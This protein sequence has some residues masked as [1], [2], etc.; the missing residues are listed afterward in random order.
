MTSRSAFS[1]FS[2][3]LAV[4]A[5]MS[6]MTGCMVDD[7]GHAY[8]DRLGNAET[9]SSWAER[10]NRT[11]EDLRAAI[12]VLGKR[13]R[14]STGD[15]GEQAPNGIVRI[16]ESLRGR[17]YGRVGAAQ[18]RDIITAAIVELRSMGADRKTESVP[19][20]LDRVAALCDADDVADLRK[21]AQRSKRDL[22]GSED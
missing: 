21:F 11:E 4:A 1:V 10:S 18:A 22:P 6:V 5:M 13:F 9:I 14:Q 20:A 15:P 3:T 12:A 17:R 7:T 16:V 19:A 8:V 2:A